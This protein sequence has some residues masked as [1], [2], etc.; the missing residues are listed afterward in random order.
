MSGR[1]FFLIVL[2]ALVSASSVKAAQTVYT[3]YDV[4]NLGVPKFVETNYIDLKKITQ[5]S[6]FRSSTGHDYHD[7]RESCRSMKHYFIAPDSTT[8]IRAPV[9]GTISRMDDDF[10]GKQVRITSDA[11]TSFDFIIFH[12]VL[13]KPLAVGDHVDEGQILGTHYGTITFSDIAVAV[14]APNGYRL[15]SYFDTLTDKAFE[16][17]QARGIASRDQMIT[18]RAAR[19]ADRY[20][21]TGQTFVNLKVPPENEYLTLTGPTAAKQT[22]TITKGFPTG[23]I[24]LANSPLTMS[25]TASS[26]LPVRLEST[27]PAVCATDGASV[28]LLA[29]G[30]CAILFRQ[31]GSDDYFEG[32]A[33]AV[34]YIT[35][36]IAFPGFV[37]ASSDT[38][39]NSFLRFLNLGT[40][41]KAL[42]QYARGLVM[43]YTP[44]AAFVQSNG[45]PATFVKC[46]KAL[47]AVSV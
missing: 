38:T 40:A 7:D 24:T 46:A 47:N 4:D 34:A 44:Y 31:P 5:I 27:S 14:N 20:Q 8:T 13:A 41:G 36:G 3:Y 35:E 29:S 25:A 43:Q 18:S 17:F 45:T 12:V 33:Q 21:C 32:T 22:V 39:A 37:I 6:K 23:N 2:V 16:A 42:G 30:T 9:A 28:I 15:V 26:G 1:L 10:V 19:D 11:Q